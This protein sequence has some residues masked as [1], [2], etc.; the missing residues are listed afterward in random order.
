[1]RLAIID[2]TAG[3]ADPGAAGP[4]AAGLGAC[5]YC[6]PIAN[7]PLISHVLDELAQG[8]IERAQVV[9]ANGLQGELERTLGGGHVW[10]IDVSYLDAS[11]SD[12]RLTV[13]A[14]LDRTLGT[15]PV[16]LHPGDCLFR[17]QVGAIGDRFRT[18]DVDTVLP[19]QASVAALRSPSDG[20]VSDT[21]VALGPATRA[22][23]SDLLS[24]ASE[25]GDL[26]ESLLTSDVR[27]AVCAQTE[28]WCYSDTTDGLLQANRMVLDALTV[29]PGDQTAGEGNHLHGRIAVSPSAYLSNCTVYGPACIGDGAVLEDSY[30]G[31]Y[32]AIGAGAVLSGVEIDNSMVLTGAVLQHPG[33][34]IESSI[35]GERARVGR[36]FQLPRGLRLR[37][38]PDSEVGFS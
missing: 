1:M 37:L 30:I 27:L 19:E 29:A 35:V 12:S 16:L 25:G 4:G 32:T 13:L 23:V 26:I 17:G 24:P 6:T 33:V 21:V 7:A 3:H 15:E 20:R 11:E 22:I 28:H 36:S 10:G 38:G 18:G 9:C 31:P 34:R 8:G 2:A 5:R 14:Q